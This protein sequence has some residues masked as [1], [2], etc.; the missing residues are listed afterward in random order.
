MNNKIT[1]LISAIVVVILIIAA[2]IAY[3]YLKDK[4]DPLTDQ[5][6]PSDTLNNSTKDRVADFTVMDNNGNMVN[7]SDF[8]GQPIVLNFWASW[9]PPCKD[10]MPAF[11]KIY[12]EYKDNVAFLMV[13]LTDGQR[14]TTEDGKAYV[15]KQGYTFP[16]YFDTKKE[17]SKAYTINSIPQTYFIDKDGT[18][19]KSFLG[20][21]NE[22][23]IRQYVELI[24]QN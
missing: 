20:G 22:K 17:G 14:E 11:N 8:F 21:I 2:V 10:E 6:T 24:S 13:D 4:T 9:C 12:G 1:L 7:L 5:Q 18:L 3:N 15:S 16:V 23:T 19:V